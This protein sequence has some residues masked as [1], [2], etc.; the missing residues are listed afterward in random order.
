[1]HEKVSCGVIQSLFSTASTYKPNPLLSDTY[2]YD[3]CAPGPGKSE[4]STIT[5]T[6]PIIPTPSEISKSETLSSTKLGVIVGC[7]IGGAILLSALLCFLLRHRKR[8]AKD[9]AER[10]A[11][12]LSPGIPNASP[13]TDKRA[14]D[15]SVKDSSSSE[16]PKF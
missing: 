8:L 3:S 1:M 4:S 12:K 7:S 16:S 15:F 2:V 13:S 6:T 9:E 10:E 11:K 5:P 14:F